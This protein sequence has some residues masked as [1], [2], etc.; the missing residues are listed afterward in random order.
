MAENDNENIAPNGESDAAQ[1]TAPLSGEALL[2]AENEA[3]RIEIAAQPVHAR[4][5]RDLGQERRVQVR[6]LGD[7]IC[8]LAST[9]RSH[10]R[11][12]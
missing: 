3:L 6:R 10:S 7:Y 2:N 1:E 9:Q 11:R 5:Q 12:A 8:L 4:Q